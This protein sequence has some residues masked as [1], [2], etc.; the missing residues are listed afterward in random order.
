MPNT[1]IHHTHAKANRK[2]GKIN[3]SPKRNDLAIKSVELDTNSTAAK[4]VNRANNRFPNH[5]KVTI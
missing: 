4:K 2:P 1:I 3:I 5:H